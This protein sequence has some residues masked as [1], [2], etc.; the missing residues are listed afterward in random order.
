MN[1]IVFIIGSMRKDSFNR[2][3]AAMAK[4]HLEKTA[5]VSV[6]EYADIPYMNQ[7]IEYPAPDSIARVRSEI[8]SADGIWIFTPEYNFS[9]PGVLKNL[10]DWLSR[11]LK[12]NDF[13]G[14]TS[15]TGKKV[16]I[17]GVGGKMKTSGVR[18]KLT[19]LLEFM[20]MDV[21]KDSTGAMINPEAWQ[22]GKLSLSEESLTELKQQADRFIKFIEENN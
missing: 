11:P 16:T 19:S 10:L 14:K 4:E 13:A 2:Q 8:E 15:V 12:P 1:K 7:D 18:E 6:L 21:M 5:E 3:M 20:R 22:T 9:Y 17:S